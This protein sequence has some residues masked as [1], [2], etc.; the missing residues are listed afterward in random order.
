MTD[1]RKFSLNPEF[2]S[3]ATLSIVYSL[4]AAF[5]SYAP[6]LHIVLPHNLSP[7]I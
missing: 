4:L 7:V 2:L 1:G 5:G 6:V 3:F